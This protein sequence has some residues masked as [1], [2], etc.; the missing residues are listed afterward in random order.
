MLHDLYSSVF[1]GLSHTVLRC[2]RCPP[3]SQVNSC[4]GKTA[5]IRAFFLTGLIVVSCHWQASRAR[6]HRTVTMSDSLSRSA[7][8]QHASNCCRC[9][10]AKLPPLLVRIS[11][12]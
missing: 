8:Q 11:R 12:S 9:A 6:P 1:D 3:Q 7:S 2:T 5:A 4:T 10:C